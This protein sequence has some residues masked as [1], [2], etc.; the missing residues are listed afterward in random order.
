[1][2]RFS[3][4]NVIHLLIILLLVWDSFQTR[5]EIQ[6]L[7][8]HAIANSTEISQLMLMIEDFWQ[9]APKEME[10]ISRKTMKEEL[11]KLEK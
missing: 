1:M 2:K 6:R 3:I 4:S 7:R 8:S 10:I 9:M 5:N 11:D